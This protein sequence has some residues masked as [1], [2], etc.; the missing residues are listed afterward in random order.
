MHSP[1]RILVVDGNEINRDLLISRLGPYGYDLI[2]AAD[3]KEAI[4]LA[5]A[6]LPDLILLDVLMPKLDGST[7]RSGSRVTLIFRLFR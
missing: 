5:R 4:E 2:Q 1:P 7:Q 3:G 6:S